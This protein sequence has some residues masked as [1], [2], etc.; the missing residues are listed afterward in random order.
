MKRQ[1]S[2]V[3]TGRTT[4]S[5]LLAACFSAPVIAAPRETDWTYFEG[6]GNWYK[7]IGETDRVTNNLWTW[8]EAQADAILRGVHLVDIH[9]AA[10]NAF[11]QDLAIRNDKWH[12]HWIGL[13]QPPNSPEPDGGW[14][15]STG[16]PVS[17]LNWGAAPGNEPEPN[18]NGGEDHAQLQGHNPDYVPDKWNDLHNNYGG[19]YVLER[20]G[21]G[22][23]PSMPQPDLG[24]DP[25]QLSQFRFEAGFRGDVQWTPLTAGAE[26]MLSIPGIDPISMERSI[27]IIETP[28][29]AG[30]DESIQFNTNNWLFGQQIGDVLSALAPID[31]TLANAEGTLG[32]RGKAE[33]T[34][35]AFLEDNQS[36]A[37]FDISAGLGV[38]GFLEA[39]LHVPAVDGI[40]FVDGMVNRSW[41]I[42]VPI[43][44]LAVSADV[45]VEGFALPFTFDYDDF[46]LTIA[47]L[48]GVDASTLDDE[49][50]EIH[51]VQG[52]PITFKPQDREAGIEV[53]AFAQ[54]YAATSATASVDFYFREIDS[55]G[56]TGQGE[57]LFDLGGVWDAAI[58]FTNQTVATSETGEVTFGPEGTFELMTGSP[59][60]FVALIDTES[61]VNVIGFDAEFL[62]EDGAEGVLQV[63]W[64]GELL[65]VIDEREASDRCVL[66][67]TSIS[68]CFDRQ[69]H[70]KY[71]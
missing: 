52:V 31:Q 22:A 30:F 18:N 13:Y 69:K 3:S 68:L 45:S 35:G 56:S 2:S 36:H 25:P 70:A 62:S 37:D 20:S 44:N 33:L 46:K 12:G 55:S 28:V 43:P 34:A 40:P 61:L 4:A 7:A 11:V 26:F 59:V 9:S 15:W 29:V 17:Y 5:L 38:F 57:S 14:Q 66:W 49:G 1:A 19:G 39:D 32:V 51:S 71:R 42:E 50:V 47:S 54:I 16:T 24:N 27:D 6:T 67:D 58:D 48:L 23:P 64:E 8:E 41:D 60:W 21:H 63:F 53:G 10:E 65:A